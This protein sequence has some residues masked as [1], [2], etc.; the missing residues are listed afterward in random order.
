M[1]LPASR[2]ASIRGGQPGRRG[3]WPD[4]CRGARGGTARRWLPCPRHRSSS[5]GAGRLSQITVGATAG[6]AD[7]PLYLAASAGLFEKGRP[8]GL[9]PDVQLGGHGAESTGDRHRE[10][11][12]RR[13]RRFF[14]AASNDP[15]L[16]ILADGYDAAPNVME[17]LALPGSGVTTPRAPGGQDDRHAAAA[18]V[19]VQYERPYSMDTMATQS[20]L[21]ADGVE[22][23][24]VKW[25]R[26]PRSAWSVPSGIIR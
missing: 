16:Q 11:R 23:T 26:C 24:Q 25:R 7:A 3:T 10:R 22:P 17:V 12:E 4:R 5:S 1:R 9:H 14:Y 6:V 13:L 20:V 21:L 2:P 19:P 8:A 18:G 15:S